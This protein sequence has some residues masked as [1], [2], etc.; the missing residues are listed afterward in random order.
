VTRGCGFGIEESVDAG[1]PI[2]QRGQ[3]QVPFGAQQRLPVGDPRLVELVALLPCP[4]R[5]LLRR[6]IEGHEFPSGIGEVVGGDIRT[7]GAQPRA[8]RAR[9]TDRQSSVLHGLRHRRQPGIGSVEQLADGD[10]GARL[11]ARGAGD[12]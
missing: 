1:H 11:G 5:H 7:R 9:R 10:Q 6:Q 8:D 2:R 4:A 3:P 12:P